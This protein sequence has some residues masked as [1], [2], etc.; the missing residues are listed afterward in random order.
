M[1]VDGDGKGK[2][3]AE[4]KEG[5]DEPEGCWLVPGKQR[6]SLTLKLWPSSSGFARLSATRQSAISN[7][8]LGL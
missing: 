7:Q 4:P 6:S 2:G 8:R 5:R 1:K 3:N